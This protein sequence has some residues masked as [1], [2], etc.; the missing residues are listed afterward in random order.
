MKVAVTGATGHIGANLVRALVERGGYQIR[1][2]V[3]D[4]DS[5]LAGLAVE[6]LRVDVRD[7]PAL[8]RAFEGVERVF[9]LAARISIAP[10]DGA[11]VDAINV[12]GTRN[13]VEA[14]LGAG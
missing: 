1:A 3:H 10:G 6:K 4:D 8:R 13:V 11:L 7:L 12:G 9:H 5:P 2:L 14:C